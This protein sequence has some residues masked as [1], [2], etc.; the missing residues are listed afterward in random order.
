MSYQALYRVWRPQ[1]F[2]DVV[3]QE[4]IAQTLQNALTAGRLSH[5]YLFNG[6]RGTGKTSA[7]KILAKAVNCLAGPGPEPCNEC[8]ACTGI[9]AGALMDVVEIDAASNRGVD[10]IRDLR[11]KVKYAPTEVRF[12]VYIIDEVHML[13][14]EAFN[15]LL[16]TLEEP[17]QHV[18]FILA[19]TEPQKLPLTIISRCQRFSFRRIPLESIVGRLREICKAQNVEAEGA[20]LSAIARIADGGMRDALSILDQCLSLREDCLEEKSVYLVTGTISREAIT[21]LFQASMKNDVVGALACLDRAIA[22]GFDPEKMMEDMIC[23]C[24]DLLMIKKA[25]SMVEPGM[26]LTSPFHELAEGVSGQRILGILDTLISYQSQMKWTPYPRVLLEMVLIRLCDVTIEENQTK[27]VSQLEQRIARLEQLIQNKE[28]P[29]SP[30]LEKGK[31]D[32]QQELQP[33]RANAVKAAS[34]KGELAARLCPER[35]IEIK[36]I[37]PEV[38]QRV[39]DE[40]ITVHAWLV[41]GEVVGATPDTVIAA[42]KSK[43]HRDTTEK[44]ANKV[45]IEQVMGKIIGVPTYL[46]TCMADE[47]GEPPKQIQEK[48]EEY[49]EQQG[50]DVVAK[51]I[52]VFGEDLVEIRS[53][54]KGE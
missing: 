48:K 53:S 27:D 19:T 6:P 28:M 15:A 1:R 7:A 4:H 51:A 36:R 17:P 37:W 26:D 34:F 30:F 24:R 10:E 2:S 35:L 21:T 14:T 47:W 32:E 31:R 45:V 42:F 13:T 39:K 11:D 22:D 12:K 52:E 44:E 16:K 20:A 49:V 54:K 29:T 40:K 41:D 8:T 9:T 3:G 43:I 5:A 50:M 38:L 33:R 18:L 46:K 25:P 23:G